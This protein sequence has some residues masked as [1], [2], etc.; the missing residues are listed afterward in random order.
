MRTPEARTTAAGKTTY[1]VRFR[2]ADSAGVVRQTSESFTNKKQAETFCALLDTLGVE[3]ALDWLYANPEMP[4]LPTL[5]VLA[6]DHF[7]NLP[8]GVLKGTEDVYRRLWDRTWGPLLGHVRV[9]LIDKDAIERGL[10]VLGTRYSNKSL[11]NQRGVLSGVMRRGVEKKY[12]SRNP[13]A[14]IKQVTGGKPGRDKSDM[15]ILT[16]DEFSVLEEAIDPH[17]RTMLRFLWGSGARWGEVVVLRARDIRWPNA[18][19]SRGLKYAPNKA[20]VTIGTTKNRKAR[21][22]WLPDDLRDELADLIATRKP[23]DLLFQL[24]KGGMIQHRQFHSRVWTPAVAHIEGTKPRIHD[25]RHSHASVLLANGVPMHVVSV[26]LGHSSVKIT[27]DTYGHLLP[28]SMKW[29]AQAAQL[30]FKPARPQ[31]SVVPGSI[32]S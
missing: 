22:I 32:E 26:R 31:L 27:G 21:T 5:N 2:R 7:D 20:D 11:R 29:A 9:D 30:G 8:S 16:L 3:G 28:D 4:A 6:A 17:Y 14:D 1:K 18:T 13:V 24:P 25:L 19:I 12:I 10:K 23:D 15:R